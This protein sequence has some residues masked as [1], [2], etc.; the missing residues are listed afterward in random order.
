[1]TANV[2]SIDRA[3]RIILG[4]V[5]LAMLLVLEGPVRWAGLLGLIL[6]GTALVG[7]CPAY[8]LLGLR[9]RRGAA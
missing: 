4:I 3:V 9:T 7:Y 6:I 2:G 5:L 1:M 8:G